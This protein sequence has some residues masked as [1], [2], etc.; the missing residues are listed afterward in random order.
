MYKPRLTAPAAG[1]PYYNTPDRNGY[2]VGIINGQ[3][4]DAGNNVLAN[5]VGYAAGRFNEIIGAGYFV[6][7]SYAPNAECF[8]QWAETYGL[9]TG[10]KPQLGA[11]AVWAKG[12]PT[13]GADGAGHVAI[14]EEIKTDGSIIT[15]ESGY[16]CTPAFWT[17]HRWKE[18]G[19]WGADGSYKFLGFVYQPDA[20]PVRALK[21][22]DTGE[23]VANL[24]ADLIRC[25]YLPSG[26]VDGI[27]GTYTLGAVLCCQFEHGL[28]VDGIVGDQTRGVLKF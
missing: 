17:S 27:F 24:Q 14:V 20:P 4:R 1:N 16:G 6:Y 26:Q 12:D 21:K 11:I 28:A 13:T 2:A 7:Y 18:S 8:F 5:C 15:S 9:K 22:G 3:P 25:G 10:D 19:N 23:D